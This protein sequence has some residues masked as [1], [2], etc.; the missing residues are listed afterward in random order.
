MC[1]CTSRRMWEKEIFEEIIGE[2]CQKLKEFNPCMKKAK[3]NPSRINVTTN[4][5]TNQPNNQPITTTHS[6]ILQLNC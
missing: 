2:Y 1:N 5:V 3:W 4:K 6:G